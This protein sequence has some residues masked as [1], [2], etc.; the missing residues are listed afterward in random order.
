[1][2]AHQCIFNTGRTWEGVWAMQMSSS[3]K[4]IKFAPKFMGL[5]LAAACSSGVVKFFT[6]IDP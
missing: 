6:P 1:M 2:Q 4:D 3:V 5:T